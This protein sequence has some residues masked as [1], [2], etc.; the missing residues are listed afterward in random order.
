MISENLRRIRRPNRFRGMNVRCFVRRVG[1][2]LYPAT[3]PIQDVG[4]DHGGTDVAVAEELPY[5]ADVVAIFQQMRGETVAQ[6][7]YAPHPY[8]ML[9]SDSS[10][11]A[12][13]SP[14]AW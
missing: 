7:W 14:L 6:G 3:A 9:D 5:G 1:G 4:V 13:Q 2:A 8:Q 10:P 12:F 11:I